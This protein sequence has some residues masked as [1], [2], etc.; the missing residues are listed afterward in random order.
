MAEYVEP[1][2]V[3]GRDRVV[4]VACDMTA[5]RDLLEDLLGGVVVGHLL[6][7]G[8]LG[9]PATSGD[10]AELLGL[11]GPQDRFSH[12]SSAPGRDWTDPGLQGSSLLLLR[13]LGR[14]LLRRHEAA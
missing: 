11:V 10:F 12:E 5:L 3:I 9:V 7:L 14:L 4:V 1:P 8:G 6:H 13:L 2:A